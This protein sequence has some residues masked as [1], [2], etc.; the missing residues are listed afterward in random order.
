MARA[1]NDKHMRRTF[2]LTTTL[3]CLAGCTAWSRSDPLD[4]LGPI[5]DFSLIER[6]G[7]QV[8]GTDL[9]GKVWIASFIFTRC[10]GPC[11]AVTGTMARLQSDLAGRDGV[12]LVTIS[13]DPDHDDPSV[14]REYADRFGADPER[15]LF[16][17]GKRAE[18]YALCNQGFRVGVARDDRE[19]TPPGEAVTHSTRLVLVDKTSHK[20][21][22]FRGESED[23]PR[24]EEAIATLLR[25]SP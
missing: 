12:V 10:N 5:G 24:L 2:A 21:G 6:S 7:R 17:T 1:R 22:Y 11:P 16:L 20:R 4:D 15:W 8:T 3:L 18:I 25:D 9:A 19:E 13:V 14:L 23:L